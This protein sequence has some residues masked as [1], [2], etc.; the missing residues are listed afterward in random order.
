MKRLFFS[1]L[2][3]ILLSGCSGI[4]EKKIGWEEEGLKGKVKSIRIV[5]YKAVEKSDEVMK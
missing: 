3:M 2:G 1:A 5:E 4:Q